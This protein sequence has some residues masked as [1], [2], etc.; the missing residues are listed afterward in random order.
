MDEQ[1]GK[2][3]EVVVRQ[4]PPHGEDWRQVVDADTLYLR[5]MADRGGYVN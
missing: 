4:G 3:F 1:V 5:G 2:R